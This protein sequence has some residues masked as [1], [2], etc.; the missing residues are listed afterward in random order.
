VP[1]VNDHDGSVK[2]FRQTRSVTRRK[3]SGRP[4]K[5]ALIV[6]DG[7]IAEYQKII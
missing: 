5:R 2:L 1:S 4:T 6:V 7:A 3:C